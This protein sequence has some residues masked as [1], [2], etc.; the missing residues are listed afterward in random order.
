MNKHELLVE[1]LRG[2]EVESYHYGAAVVCD[3]EGNI[4]KS[5][6]DPHQL[7]FPR[8]ALKHIQA[9][10]L[11]ESGAAEHFN[12]NKSEIALACASHSAED[13]HTRT[14]LE[15]LNRIGLCEDNL[16]CGTPNILKEPTASFML[17]KNEQPT[18]IHNNCSGKHIGFLAATVFQKADVRSY[19][20]YEHPVQQHSFDII[21]DLAQTDVRQSPYGE[22]GCG[23]PIV[24]MPLKNLALCMARFASARTENHKRKEAIL[25]IHDAITESP[26]HIAGTMSTVSDIIAVTKG[27][28]L[29]KTGAEGIYTANIPERGIGIAV[30][31]ADGSVRARS[32]LILAILDQLGIFTD[33]ERQGLK[34]HMSPVVTNTLKHN[35]GGIRLAEAFFK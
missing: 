22:D 20:K 27:K 15:I 33:E 18:K 26:Y 5:W 25:T 29:A 16:I 3:A 21:N 23:F 8:S 10:T 24:T 17:M 34:K 11:V 14:G 28:V 9:L 1:V 31:I 4:L 12:F 13:I 32:V 30:K 6:G 7:V 2:G 19:Y 35:I